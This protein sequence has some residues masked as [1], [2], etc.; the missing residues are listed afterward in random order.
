M[1]ALM[2]WFICYN[3]STSFNA[4]REFFRMQLRDPLCNCSLHYN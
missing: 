1:Y 4:C 2:I 3:C